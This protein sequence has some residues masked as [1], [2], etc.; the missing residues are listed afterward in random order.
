M[1][2]RWSSRRTRARHGERIN[3]CLALA[4][5]YQGRVITTVEGLGA[6]GG[7]HPLQRAFIEHDG[8][9][10]GYCTPGQLC[11]AVAMA[12]EVERAM[13]EMGMGTATVQ[14]QHVAE[15]LGL[16]LDQVTFDYGDTS[17]PAGSVA[18]GSSQTASVGAAVIAASDQDRPAGVL[19][20]CADRVGTLACGCGL[21]AQSAAVVGVERGDRAG[22]I[23]VLAADVR[24]S[25]I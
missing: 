1:G 7:L 14:A 24:P 11:S 2:R 20:G 21:E 19:A 13:Q 5:Q 23:P 10:C 25:W 16:P 6:E 9:Q 8:F 22:L 12:G 15:R 18:G 4:V 3:S 17:L